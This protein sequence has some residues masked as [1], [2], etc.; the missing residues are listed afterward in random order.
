MSFKIAPLILFLATAFAN[1]TVAQ[2]W[3]REAL[4][5][6][7]IEVLQGDFVSV[8][9]VAVTGDFIYSLDFVLNN[10]D[11]NEANLAS[12]F[13]GKSVLSL[14]EG[15]SGLLPFLLKVGVK[16][17]GLDLW[18]GDLVFPDNFSGHGMR[19]YI[20]KYGDHLIAG[21]ARDIPL[22]DASTDLVLSHMLVN[23]VDIVA[24][25]LIVKEV[26]RILSKD[27]EARILGFGRQTAL[28]IG[29]FLKTNISQC[30]I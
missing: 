30:A 2:E 26:V 13:R 4:S 23:N 28:D 1:P 6:P 17:Q 24:Q 29:E 7:A 8:N 5:Q 25:K 18:Y 10:L 27:G 11:L 20:R 21:D 14:A 3:C 12:Q 15:M 16:A 19:E 9:G 22:P